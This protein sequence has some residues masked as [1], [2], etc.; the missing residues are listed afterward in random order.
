MPAPKNLFKQALAERRPQIGLWL[1]LTSPYTAEI[2]AGAGYD[3]L[4]LDGEH[5]PNDIPSLLSQLQAIGTASHA[6]VR[7]PIGETWLIKQV[8]DIGAQS[9]LVPMVESAEQAQALVRAVR[10]PPHGMRGVGAALARA[11]AFNRIP[12]YLQTANAEICLLVQVETLSALEKAAEIAAVD[13]VDGVFIGPSDLAADMGFLGRPGA[14][15]VLEAI[16]LGLE[17]IHG[18]GKPSGI[19]TSD[20]MLARRYLADGVSFLAIGTDVGLLGQATTR[21]LAAFHGS[22]REKPATGSVY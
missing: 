19:L 16:A 18:A 15:E 21:H 14:P 8:L 2:C 10:Y 13:G 22:A 4:L 3:W 7:P 9:L 17:A 11:S 20:L 1:G 5:A 12:D 6:V